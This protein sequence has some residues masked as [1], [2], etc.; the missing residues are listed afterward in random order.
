[1]AGVRSGVLWRVVKVPPCVVFV[2]AK[3]MGDCSLFG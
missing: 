3:A 2:L 1:M